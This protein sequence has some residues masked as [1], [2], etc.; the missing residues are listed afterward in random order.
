MKMI[1][2]LYMNGDKRMMEEEE[3]IVFRDKVCEP[4][5]NGK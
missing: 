3:E 1:S 2:N 5:S 4:I